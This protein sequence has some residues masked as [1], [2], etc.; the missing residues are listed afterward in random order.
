MGWPI[1]V[2]SAFWKLSQEDHGKFG[3]S[4]G[5]VS[6]FQADLGCRVRA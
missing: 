4:L 2:I 1:P 3:D 5:Y 6:E